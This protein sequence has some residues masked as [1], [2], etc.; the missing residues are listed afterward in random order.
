MTAQI[1]EKAICLNV[2]FKLLGITRK[3]DT[4]EITVNADKEMLNVTK[5]L[6]QS[7]E[8]AAITHRDGETKR[9]LHSRA[10]PSLFRAGVYLVPLPFVQEID[11]RLN[12]IAKDRQNLVDK[13]VSVYPEM[14]ISASG[15][16]RG[17]FE[18]GDYPEPSKV[19][20]MF[21]MSWRYVDLGV[22]K[23]L[24]GISQQMFKEQ[25]EKASAEW[26]EAMRE[27]RSLLRIGMSD[28]V[29]DMVTKLTPEDG[30]K[31]MFRAGMTDKIKEFLEV[32]N[33]RNI[34]DDTELRLL[35]DKVRGMLRGINGETIKG[36]EL[37]QQKLKVGFGQIKEQLAT[38]IVDR[39]SRGISFEEE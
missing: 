25:Q 29:S 23:G 16:L 34:A 17:I 7:R 32:F 8:F 39:P 11:G 2:S 20:G 3:V 1:G 36:S 4:S 10:L 15:K 27:V 33:A 14:V 38:M 24:S 30:K 31:K 21:G 6:F 28:L 5:K 9:Y 13:F 35:T 12:A 18:A 19:G 26:V 22:P 37:L